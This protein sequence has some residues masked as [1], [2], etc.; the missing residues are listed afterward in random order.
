MMK[1]LP[2]I[3]AQNSMIVQVSGVELREVSSNPVR[4]IKHSR[5]PCKGCFLG[6]SP[7]IGNLRKT[8]GDSQSLRDVTSNSGVAI[9]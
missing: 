6:N 2:A 7:T 9:S 5:Q 8:F 4:D 1:A 3:P